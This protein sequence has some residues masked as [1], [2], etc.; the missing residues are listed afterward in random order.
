MSFIIY[1]ED[2]V[3]YDEYGEEIEQHIYV[4]LMVG[5]EDDDDDD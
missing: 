3:E 5:N 4:S 2:E 1:D